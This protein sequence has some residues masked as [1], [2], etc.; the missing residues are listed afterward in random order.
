MKTHQVDFKF[1]VLGFTP[2]G[3]LWGFP[4]LNTL[5]SCG[6]RTLRQNLEANMELVDASGQRWIVRSV[7]RTGRAE[8]LALWLISHLIS[9]PQSRIEHDLDPMAPVSLDEVKARVCESM[10]LHPGFYRDSGA[11]EEEELQRELTSV[12]SAKSISEIQDIL[13]PDSFMAY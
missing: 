2:N 13:G 3:E 7:R 1:P 10:E 5:T 11:L 8:G 9:T 4:D 6:P 12:R